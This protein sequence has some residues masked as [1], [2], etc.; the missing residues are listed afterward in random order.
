MNSYLAFRMAGVLAPRI[1][2]RLSYALVNWLANALYAR[3]LETVR[4]LR[5]NLRHALGPAASLDQVHAA[6]RRA[7]RVL[8]LNYLD[9]FRLAALNDSQLRAVV[10]VINW[11]MVESARALGRGVL[12][13]SAHLGHVEAGL[14]MVALNGLPVTGLAEHV[15]PERLYQYLV[16]L[17]TRHGL[18]FI[19]TDGPML[20]LFRALHRNEGVGTML[21]RD[22]TGSGVEVELC[23]ARAHVPDGYAHIAAKLRTPLVAGF[24]Y[25]LP[26]GRA[27]IKLEASFVPDPAAERD[28][29]YRAALEFGVRQLE[30]VVSTRP[31]QWILTTPI[32]TKDTP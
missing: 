25:R 8:L 11:D 26:D 12:M 4:N 31:D 29:V 9:M 24:C 27:R 32:W 17:R 13:C 16:A 22:T 19:P 15:Q 18:R 30:R 3:D 10:E 28:Q 21:D 6:A 7:Y 5:D 2:R 23:G 20:E 1:P 14:Q